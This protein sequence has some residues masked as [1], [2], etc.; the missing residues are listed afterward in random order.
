[1]T[2]PIT[3]PSRFSRT[4]W[5]PGTEPPFEL[6]PS[7]LPVERRDSLR[8]ALKDEIASI[9]DRLINSIDFSDLERLADR[10]AALGDARDMPAWARIA[11]RIREHAEV[12]DIEQLD[13]LIRE[14]RKEMAA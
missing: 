1:M 12:F 14:M 10:L 4:N 2:R 8:K 11:G 5:R 6:L 7:D 3:S 13:R 9:L